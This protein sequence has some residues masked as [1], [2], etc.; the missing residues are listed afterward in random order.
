[1]PLNGYEYH[2][3]LVV[4]DLS[5]VD[6]I[7]GMDFLKA[8]GVTINLKNDTVSLEAGTLINQLTECADRIPVRLRAVC[9]LLTGYLNR[10]PVQVEGAA[11]TGT[12]LFESAASSLGDALCQFDAQIVDVRDGLTDLFVEHRGAGPSLQ[13]RR[14]G[15]L[16]GLR[17][18]GATKVHILKKMNLSRAFQCTH[19]TPL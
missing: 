19:W 5:T 8:Y 18:L 1:M 11:L 3:N 2:V 13:M 12:F 15:V 10:C 4:A 17:Q 14:R 7:L 9:T 16:G 6:A